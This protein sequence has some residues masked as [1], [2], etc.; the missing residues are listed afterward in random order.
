MKF[1]NQLKKNKHQSFSFLITMIFLYVAFSIPIYGQNTKNNNL[2]LNVQNQPL[3]EVFQKI[4]ALTNYKFFYDQSIVDK[5]P[6][7][8]LNVR[9]TTIQ[10]ILS[11]ITAQTNLHF[12]Q[13]DNTISVSSTPPAG[14]PPLSRQKQSK[15]ISGIITDVWGEPIIGANIVEKGTTNGTITDI[16]GNFT[17][18]VDNDAVLQISYIG[19]LKQE[20]NA[21][22]K[23]TINITLEEDTKSLEEVVVV[24]YGVQ[25][26][27]NLTGAVSSV[28]FDNEAMQSRAATNVSTMLA[29]MS[30]GIQVRQTDGLPSA[31]NNANI[32]V[33][34]VGSLNASQTPLVIIDGVIANINTVSPNDVASVSILKDAASAAIYG[35]RASNGVILITTKS[36]GD[37]G[38]K[39][40][41]NYNNFLGSRGPTIM[42]DVVSNTAD[43]MHL[44]NVVQR[45][46][47]LNAPF[48][49]E[50][51]DEWREKSQ[52]DPIGYPNTDWTKALIKDNFVMNHNLSARGGNDRLNFF[53][54]FDYF[55]DDGMIV[56]TGYKRFNFRNNLGYKVN[57]W[58]QLGNNLAFRTTTAEPADIGPIF[59]WWRATSPGMVPKHPDGRY[60]AAQ[61]PS[62]ETGANNPLMQAEQQRG[63]SK[64]N[65]LQGK[66]FAVLTP[67]KGLSV[68]ASYFVDFSFNES[69]SGGIPNDRWDFQRDLMVLPAGS[70]RLTLTNSYS[71][72]QREIIDLFADYT[73]S[74]GKHTVKILGGFNQEEYFQRNFSAEKRD[75]LSYD[76]PVL[77]AAPSEPQAGG[78]ASDYAM[79]SFFSRLNYDYAGKY[80]FE[81]N[82][83]YDGSSRFAPNKRWGAFPSFSAG[84]VISEELFW[85]RL[86]N[87]VD[88]FKIRTSWGQLGNN[89]IGNYEWQEFYGP[90]NYTLNKTIIPGLAYSA[91]GNPLITWETTNVLNIGTDI[92]LFNSLS[93]DINYYSKET[94]D[95]LANLPIPLVNGGLTAPRFNSARVKNSGFE[96]EARYF[97]EFGKLG[98][99]LGANFSYNKNRILSYKG[100]FI[101]PRGTSQ[102]W[103][104]GHPIGVYW[105][106]EVDYIVQDQS[107]VDAL[108]AQGYTFQPST[109][110]RGD[111]MYKDADGNKKID[112]DD[113]V[114]KGNPIPLY[115]YGASLGLKYAGWDFNIFMDGVGGWDK[116]QHGDLF[117]TNRN[118]IGYLWPTSYMGM[119]TEE[120]PSTTLP[121][122][123]TNNTKNNQVSDFFLHSAAYTRIRS[124]QLGYS[125]P[126]KILDM[127]KF[128]EIR[129]FANLENYFTFTNWPGQD[130]EVADGTSEAPAQT[131]PIPKT[132]S[133]GLN[134][135][136]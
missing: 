110:G 104:E 18:S 52:T 63:E 54:S 134:V 28:Y 1:T 84:W 67:A 76:T 34:G 99:T 41:F 89:G 7:I 111:F 72:N 66:L 102:A 14:T 44:I 19:Y 4:S 68:T 77:D 126:D 46:S 108:I 130:P 30:A 60:G 31:N 113:R 131:Y 15:T 70:Y 25:K 75:L 106:R 38:G 117:S 37:T 26:R 32:S 9:D 103:T 97:K 45:N 73:T 93:L 83:R 61:T 27:Q 133:F 42:H 135:S 59:T 124:I 2:S 40:T 22:G 98:V 109:P 53:T 35:S 57:D 78:N 92:R 33:R 6:N 86:K 128:Q 132:V 80:L 125:L 71:R 47:G 55:K 5:A 56:N 21:T 129:I 49:Q 88:N 48:T 94:R 58:L 119:W 85:D 69:W 65:N 12:Q 107:V 23:V 114:L 3:S 64:A 90:A 11:K 112:N 36:G 87:T 20:I 29:G 50:Q 122:M 136:F 82:L 39:I 127:L 91:F 96:T 16:D 13:T 118:I 81:A 123:Y 116:Y 62:G 17:L 120:N 79:R 8:T 51:I 24:G 95:I 115:T 121:K 105:V 74:F 101:E 100:D 10:A 43:H